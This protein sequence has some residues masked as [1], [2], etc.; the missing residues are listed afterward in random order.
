MASI[1]FHLNNQIEAAENPKLFKGSSSY[2]NGEQR[3][4]FIFVGDV[5]KVNLW[6]LENPEVSGI[7]NMGTGNC[8]S[9]KEVAESVLD[10]HGKGEIEF[11]PFPDHLKG[12]YQSFTKQI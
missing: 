8:Q 12:S 7:F 6:M 9:F 4:D 2:G 11:I 5:V 10:Y 1:A 3:R